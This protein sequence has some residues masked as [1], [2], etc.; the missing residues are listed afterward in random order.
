MYIYVRVYSALKNKNKHNHKRKNQTKQNKT[1]RKQ[2]QY[3]RKTKVDEKLIVRGTYVKIQIQ[4]KT[5]R[6]ETT[7][8]EILWDHLTNKGGEIEST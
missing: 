2:R 4:K 8:K 3:K 6:K 7:K 5:I 1:K